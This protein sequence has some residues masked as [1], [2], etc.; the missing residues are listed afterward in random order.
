M[1]AYLDFLSVFGSDMQLGDLRFSDFREQTLLSNTPRGVVAPE[2]GRS[3]Q[4]FQICYNIKSVVRESTAKEPHREQ[5]WAIR[6]AAVQHQFDVIE[7]TT[8]WIMTK[9]DLDFKENV[10]E[11]TGKH[12]RPEDRAFGSVPE[13]FKSS[14]VIHLM[15]W[16]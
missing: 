7:G 5:Q 4:Q 10:Q 2:M 3:G 8:L 11:V 12:G 9:T 15:C 14:L 6:Q 16:N 13:C 1:P